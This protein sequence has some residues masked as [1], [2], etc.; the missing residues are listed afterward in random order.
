MGKFERILVFF[1]WLI[2]I[3]IP[4]TSL[5][6]GEEVP[7]EE[8]LSRW[9]MLEPPRSYWQLSV[10]LYLV[11]FIIKAPSVVLPSLPS[12]YSFTVLGLLSKNVN[13]KPLG[14][15]SLDSS[16]LA[17]ANVYLLPDICLPYKLL[18]GKCGVLSF[19]SSLDW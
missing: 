14:S 18:L 4:W 17:L 15:N 11:C 5:R 3:P 8:S 13:F 19:K 16:A 12:S 10:S 7:V 2:N 6:A 1:H 9:H